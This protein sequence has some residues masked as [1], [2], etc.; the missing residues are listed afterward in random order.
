MEKLE[1]KEPTLEVLD[2]NKT[3]ASTFNFNSLDN[4]YESG[5][6][7]GELGWS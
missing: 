2:I 6:P 1:W 7:W 4:T 3:M 5:T